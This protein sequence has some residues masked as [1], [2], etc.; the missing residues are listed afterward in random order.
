MAHRPCAI[1]RKKEADSGE[2]AFMRAGSSSYFPFLIFPQRHTLIMHF[3]KPFSLIHKDN[4]SVHGT[5]A[6]ELVHYRTTLSTGNTSH[7]T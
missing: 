6:T 3:V 2:T 4:Y 1:W 5:A 7:K